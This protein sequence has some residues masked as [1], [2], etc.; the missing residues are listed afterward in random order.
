MLIN[1]TMAASD[2]TLTGSFF[3]AKVTALQA[4]MAMREYNNALRGEQ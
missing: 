2:R 4:A 3:E 1:A